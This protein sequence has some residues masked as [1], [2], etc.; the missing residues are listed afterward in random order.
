MIVVS[1]LQMLLASISNINIA[2][3]VDI[4]GI[5][6]QGHPAGADL[7]MQNVQKARVLVRTVEAAVQALY[8]DGAALML[9]VQSYPRTT[10]PSTASDLIYPLTR[11]IKSNIALVHQTFQELLVVGKEQADKGQNDYRASME[12]RM[13]RIISMDPSLGQTLTAMSG[14]E[15]GSLGE[16]DDIVDLATAFKAS[17]SLDRSIGSSAL[18]SNPSHTSDSSLEGFGRPRGASNAPAPLWNRQRSDSVLSLTPPPSIGAGSDDASIFPDDEC[19]YLNPYALA[20]SQKSSQPS[21]QVPSFRQSL[22]L[23]Q[24]NSFVCSGRHPRISLTSSTLRLNPGTCDPHTATP[25]FLSTLMAKY[26]LGPFLLL[27]SVLL[28]MS[29]QV[30]LSL[31]HNSYMS[32]SSYRFQILLSRRRSS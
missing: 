4:D 19:T 8:D 27:W 1:W 11:S 21:R 30:S 18:Y 20:F 25:K 31:S 29:I 28:R 32:D 6:R 10:V 12:W 16:A 14:L 24:I 17:G 22:L 9:T 13:S 2:R 7:Y 15:E 5:S 23:G 26:G 3:T